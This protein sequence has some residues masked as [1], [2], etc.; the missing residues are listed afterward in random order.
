MKKPFR[1]QDEASE[2]LDHAARWYE[3][4]RSGLGHRFLASVDAT[5]DQIQRFPGAGAPV[6]EVPKDLPV[7][8]A[9]VKGFPHQVIYLET[10]DT[11]HLLAFAHD[12][13]RPAYWLPRSDAGPFRGG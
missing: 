2:E 8:Q 13:R 12:K 10:T 1:A 9:P 11:I 6:P 5:L 7:R 3:E 4:R